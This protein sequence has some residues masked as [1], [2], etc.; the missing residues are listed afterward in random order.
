MFERLTRRLG[1]LFKRLSGR[2]KLSEQNVKEALR[3]VRVALLEA[4]VNLRVVKRFLKGVKE[5]AL[6][7]EVLDSLTPGQHFIGVVQ[8]RLRELLERSDARLNLPRPALLMLVGLQGGGKTTTAAKLAKR[9]GAEGRSCLLV[10]TDTRRPA[11]R[12]QLVKLADLIKA[13]VHPRE[14]FA[15]G[16]TATALAGKRLAEAHGHEL[17]I[18]DTAGRLQLDEE[19]MAELVE[20]K[21]ALRPQG[22]WL[23]VDAMTGQEALNVAEA[24]HERLELDGVI[25]S[26]LDGDARGGCI[27]SI[28]GG[29][30]LPVR[31]VGT[32]ERPD[33]LDVFRP[34]GL[35]RRILGLGDVIGLADKA[36][37]VYDED[38]A[39]KLEKK[40]LKGGFDLSDF[41]EQLRGIAKMGDLSEI[42][43]M[44]PGM[45]SLAAGADEDQLQRELRRSE[46]V[47]GSMTPKERRYPNIINGSRRRRIARG[48]GVTVA[49][50]NQLLNQYRQMAKAF[51]GLSGKKGRRKLKAMGLDPRNL[52]GELPPGL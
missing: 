4:D 3:E 40:L 9:F 28:A 6:G 43:G 22:V 32:G 1:G 23:V 49:R 11:A 16:P 5:D 46:A 2:G 39:K 12:E 17:T 48:S 25:V 31:F 18:V 19:L 37:R 41:A 35:S 14:P 20:Q 15:E 26:K 7:A 10:A 30:G 29:L 51:S 47:I 50:V 44:V 21:R 24:F 33:D 52:D 45:R 42:I 38:Q 27:L 34:D 36:R 8:R 13:E